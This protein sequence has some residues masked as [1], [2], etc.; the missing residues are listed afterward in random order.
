[1]TAKLHCVDVSDVVQHIENDYIG[2]GGSAD[3]A[4]MKLFR[5]RLTDAGHDGVCTGPLENPEEPI[6]FAD[7]VQAACA[8]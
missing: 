8:A 2:A 4:A 5:E 7:E 1:M 3:D 6:S